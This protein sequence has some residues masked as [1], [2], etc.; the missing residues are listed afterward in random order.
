MA[1]GIRTNKI[2][3][4][5]SF[6]T[7]KRK[8]AKGRKMTKAADKLQ[9]LVAANL[10]NEKTLSTKDK[11]RMLKKQV[12]KDYKLNKKMSK[13]KDIEIE[14]VDETELPTAQNENAINETEQAVPE[15]TEEETIQEEENMA[16]E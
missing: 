6:H 13:D 3:T 11:K 2:K 7:V 4:G 12:K 14:D 1:Y 9:K 10:L 5:G 16:V 8:K 15:T